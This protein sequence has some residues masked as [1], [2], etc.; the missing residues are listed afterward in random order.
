MIWFENKATITEELAEE[1]KLAL[2][3]FENGRYGAAMV[4]F[5]GISL[6]LIT[7]VVQRIFENPQDV[8]KSTQFR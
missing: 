8:R 5:L 4:L 2:Y 3:I 7:L 1:V 6:I